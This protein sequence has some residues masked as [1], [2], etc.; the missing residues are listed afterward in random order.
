MKEINGGPYSVT[1]INANSFSLD[2]IDSTTYGVWVNGGGV[3]LKEFYQTKTWVRAYGG[4]TGY[5]HWLK[6][7]LN[8]GER[9]FRLHAIKCG[10][11]PRGKRLI[12]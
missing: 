9:P 4:G 11:R 7:T 2:G 5:T 8:G 12:N 3:Y 1:V 6:V 10:F